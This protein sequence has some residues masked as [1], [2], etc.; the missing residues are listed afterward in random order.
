MALQ[1][2]YRDTAKLVP[3]A[4]NARV[5]STLQVTQISKSIKQ[6]GFN[7]PVLIDPT[8]NLIA[9]HGRVLAAKLLRMK[10]VPCVVLSHLNDKQRRAYVIADNKLSLNST[11]DMDMLQGE[12]E[13]LQDDGFDLDGLGLDFEFSDAADMDADVADAE[14]NSASTGAETGDNGASTAKPQKNE[15]PIYLSISRK[16][17][18]RW[19]VIRGTDTDNEAFLKIMENQP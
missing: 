5:H 11:W 4:K 8:G 6:F 14:G 18:E 2:E 16:E 9:G 10:Q 3:Y 1:I 13:G 15:Y 7:S 19:K 17:Y 12:I